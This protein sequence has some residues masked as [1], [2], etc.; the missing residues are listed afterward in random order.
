M[1]RIVSMD[2]MKIF[3]T[4]SNESESVSVNAT[5]EFF[6]LPGAESPCMRPCQAGSVPMVC[7]YRFVVE[8]YQTMSRACYDCPMNLTDCRRPQC[9]PAD[10]VSRPVL[11]VNRQMPGPSIQ[12]WTNDTSIT[13]IKHT[14]LQI[15]HIHCY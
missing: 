6:L 12:V 7:R 9:I 11:V 14:L 1:E 3:V 10:G 5:E 4:L 13:S 8:W 15:E 2:E